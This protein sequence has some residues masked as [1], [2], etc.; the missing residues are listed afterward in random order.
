[1]KYEAGLA[2]RRWWEL[3]GRDVERVSD[4]VTKM[5]RVAVL[6]EGVV[7]RATWRARLRVCGRC[8]VYARDW[9][10]CLLVDGEERSGCGCYVPFVA[11]V[12]RPYPLGCWWR[13]YVDDEGGWPAV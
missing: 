1:M 11:L 7:D 3:D 6:G 13:E 10:Q 4:L 12:K 8:P 2:D 5:V 9:K